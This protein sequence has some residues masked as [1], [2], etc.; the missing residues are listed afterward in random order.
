MYKVALEKYLNADE[1]KLLKRYDQERLSELFEKMSS[2]RGI[3][4]IAA[5]RIAKKNPDA[6]TRFVSIMYCLEN[7]TMRER[8][9]DCVAEVEKK[10]PDVLSTYLH[11][12]ERA[13]DA[14][15]RR[16]LTEGTLKIARSAPECL[17]EY[18]GMFLSM[19]ENPNS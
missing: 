1:I 14:V 15:M 18:Y 16:E 10:V 17:A 3:V 8:V 12:M 6:V 9:S 11:L 7:D 5:T 19:L 2:S 4:A 13:T